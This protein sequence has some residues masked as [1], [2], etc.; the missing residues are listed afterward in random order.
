MTAPATYSC[1][2]ESAQYALTAVGLVKTFLP[3]GP[4][5]RLLARSAVR[6]PVTAVDGVD[7]RVRRG[8]VFGILGPN[9]A[10][11]TTFIKMMTTLLRPTSGSATVAGYDV[12]D[13]EAGVRSEVG[14]LTGDERSFYLRLTA[15]Q[16][17]M[18]FAALGGLSGRVAADRVQELLELMGLQD[19]AEDMYYSFS[20]GMRQKLG[21]ARA[22]LCDPS[23]LFLDEPTR[24]VDVV[25]SN[26]LKQ[27]IRGRLA[28]DGRSVILAT[29]RMEEAEQLCDRIGIMLAGRIVFCGTV[30][31]LRRSSGSREVVAIS[32]ADLDPVA[33]MRICEGRN[34]QDAEIDRPGGNG[35][36]EVR[37]G[38]NGRR[39]TLSEILADILSAG[40]MVLA[41]DRRERR[42]EELF[43]DVVSGGGESC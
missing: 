1:D 15:R 38:V 6:E 27:L 20:T 31:E 18:F 40:G 7:L 39:E 33:C 34:Q 41:C 42:L 3:P 26:E 17:L 23:V 28:T 14:L 43:I 21:I 25:A 10:G 8:E 13:A 36:V 22:L 32:V 29:H 24:G 37:L 5:R 19:R 4:I 2:P 30:E 12:V 35:L 11:K 16:N 9:G